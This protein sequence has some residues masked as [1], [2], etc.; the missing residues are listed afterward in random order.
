MKL[1]LVDLPKLNKLTQLPYKNKKLLKKKKSSVNNV[2]APLYRGLD[3]GW[4]SL[5]KLEPFVKKK[6]INTIFNKKLTSSGKFKSKRNFTIK[7]IIKLQKIAIKSNNY[8]LYNSV[9]SYKKKLLTKNL[10]VTQTMLWKKRKLKYF[11]K[12]NKQ[13]RIRWNSNILFYN[14]FFY[15]IISAHNLKYYSQKL[16]LTSMY[17]KKKL[18]NS[19][20]IF[21]S[22]KLFYLSSKIFKIKFLKKIKKKKLKNLFSNKLKKSLFLFYKFLKKTNQ[23]NNSVNYLKNNKTTYITFYNTYSTVV[24]KLSVCRLSSKFNKK[25]NIDDNLNILNFL[26]NYQIKSLN[27]NK[28]LNKNNYNL[29]LNDSKDLSRQILKCFKKSTIFLKKNNILKNSISL[30]KHY[31]FL[32][33][34]IQVF[35]NYPEQFSKVLKHSITKQLSITGNP[36]RLEKKKIKKY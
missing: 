11:I 4:L 1:I 32:K 28:T 2:R 6:K 34:I 22:L 20:F 9:S 15:N 35:Y 29:N 31:F 3:N 8:K 7:N 25:L 14:K 36:L 24:N 19:S 26:K 18:K 27:L 12:L 21:K 5:K 16:L 23:I 33:H 13:L 10:I 17:I 30:F